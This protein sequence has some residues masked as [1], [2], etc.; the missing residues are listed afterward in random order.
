MLTRSKKISDADVQTLRQLIIT[1]LQDIYWAEGKLLEAL[2]KMAEKAME[3]ALRDAFK[4][5]LKET[6]GQV[7]RLKKVFQLFDE[8]AKAKKCEA[9]EGLSK[10][11]DEMI[12]ETPA[13][14]AL[15]DCA[16]IVAAQK[17]EHY[18]I[19]SY[20]CLR[21]LSRMMG[22][23]Q[24]ADLLQETLDEEHNANDLLTELAEG[25]INEEAKEE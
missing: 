13:N 12:K 16:L 15:R 4:N 23:A 17:V 3:P 2:P 24:A 14:S 10:E 5:H 8:S 18:E 6:E 7:A 9:M 22:N 20:G 25:F 19:A 1:Q 21:T 11:A